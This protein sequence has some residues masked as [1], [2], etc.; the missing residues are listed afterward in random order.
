MRLVAIALAFLMLAGCTDR[1]PEPVVDTPAE[2]GPV[3]DLWNG[4]SE[5]AVLHIDEDGT[6]QFDVLCLT[7]GGVNI[8]RN[9]PGLVLPGSDHLTFRM[10]S[11][12]TATGLQ[13]GYVLDRDPGYDETVEGNITWL[14]I[15][16][17]AEATVDVPVPPGASETDHDDLLWAFYIRMN[18]SDQTDCYTGAQAT[19]RLVVEVT[20][21]KA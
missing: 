8:A 2:P 20:A 1:A 21:I 5:Q 16:R 17:N 15:V 6:V 3:T 9:T 11:P 13:V 10:V 4:T 7:G 14:G 12:A 19:G 18:A